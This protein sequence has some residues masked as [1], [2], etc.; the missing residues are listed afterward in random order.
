MLKMISEHVRK[1]LSGLERTDGDGVHVQRARPG[2]RVEL[3]GWKM[4]RPS[5]TLHL[6]ITARGNG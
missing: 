2:G 6:G 3:V 1:I 5:A 4:C